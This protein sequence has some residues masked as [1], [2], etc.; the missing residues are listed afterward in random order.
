M[1]DVLGQ[2]L[3]AQSEHSLAAKLV[4]VTACSWAGQWVGQRV[5]LKVEQ[6][7]MRT[8]GGKAVTR[9][10]RSAA[11]TALQRVGWMA[12]MSAGRTVRSMA[13]GRG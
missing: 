7:G 6:L 13:A 12:A 9:G 3:V 10:D 8:A 1:A 4:E 2:Y 5:Y 11:T